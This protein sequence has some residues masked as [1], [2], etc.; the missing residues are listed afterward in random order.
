[1][2]RNQKVFPGVQEGHSGKAANISCSDRVEEGSSVNGKM[3]YS[4]E[5]IVS[6]PSCLH[7]S[8][9]IM[10]LCLLERKKSRLIHIC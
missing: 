5:M 9:F 7:L 10:L 4:K 1:M 6:L 2:P 8:T 3:L